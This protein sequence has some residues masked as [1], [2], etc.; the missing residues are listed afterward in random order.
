MINWKGFGRKLPWPNRKVL[1]R[2]SSG[3]TEENHKN[4]NQDNRPRPRFE[5]G[6]SR[7]RSRSVNHIGRFSKSVWALKQIE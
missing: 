1:T 5:P 6:T 7:T 2:H 3:G 4:L